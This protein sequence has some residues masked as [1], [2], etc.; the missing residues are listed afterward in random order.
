[1]R[2]LITYGAVIFCFLLVMTIAFHTVASP[3][4]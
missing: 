4:P 2:T 3:K 1:M